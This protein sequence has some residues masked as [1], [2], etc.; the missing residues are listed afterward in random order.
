MKDDTYDVDIENE[1]YENEDH[2]KIRERI[3]TEVIYKRRLEVVSVASSEGKMER[4]IWR[5][6][7]EAEYIYQPK[8]K[9]KKKEKDMGL[10]ALKE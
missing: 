8:F 4:R 6:G 9:L 3:D 5:D 1:D 7:N 10:L 2:H